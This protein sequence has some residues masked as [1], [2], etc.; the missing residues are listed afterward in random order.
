MERSPPRRYVEDGSV[1]GAVALVARGDDA[2]GAGP[3]AGGRAGG[4]AATGCSH[5]PPRA[6]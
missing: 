3:A 4:R 2:E 5:L 1:P 6:G